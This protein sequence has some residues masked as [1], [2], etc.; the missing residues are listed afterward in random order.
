MNLPAGSA[1]HIVSVQDYNNTFDSNS[2]TISANG[3]EK[4]NG[5]EGPVQLSS[6]GEG[7]TL[8]YIDATVGWRSIQDSDFAAVG[9]NYISA[10]GGTITTSGN[11]KIH[12]FTG[13][14][15]FEVTSVA[16]TPANNAVALMVVAGGGAGAGGYQSG[17]GGAGG[18]R[19]FQT[20]PI[21][22][23]TASP[24]VCS[25]GVTVTATSYPIV[26][27]GGGTGATSNNTKGTSGVNSSALSKTSAGGGAA[28]S[29]SSPNAPTNI[30]TAGGSGG[31]AGR[32]CGSISGGAGN[33]P[34]VSPSQGFQGGPTANPY[35]YP[36]SGGGGGGATA[37]GT[38]VSNTAVGT[39]GAGATTT[40]S[41]SP[42]A[43]AGGGGGGGYAACQPSSVPGNSG[44]GGAGG[45]GQGAYGLRNGFDGTANTGGGA[46][47]SALPGYNGGNGGSGIVI[48]RYRYQ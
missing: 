15:T 35:T 41:G 39:G 30:G 7:L 34:P 11:D 25:T 24:I 38:G 22:P 3:S 4:I 46:G 18:F 6:E 47:G 2:L 32:V 43:Y 27:G 8:I 45:G 17:G 26:I 9:S 33:T 36:F 23:Y 19:E 14:G 5:G 44:A 1:G 42:T 28:G 16:S 21:T 12:T 37:Q 29:F 10:T 31:G 48:I 20:S 40:I 13:P